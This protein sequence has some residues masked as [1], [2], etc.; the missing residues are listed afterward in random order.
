MQA[1]FPVPAR[2]ERQVP[3]SVK[4]SVALLSVIGAEPNASGRPSIRPERD[5][6]LMP[7]SRKPVMRNVPRPLDP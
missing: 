1:P 3:D 7:S 2:G 4:R 6:T 5:S